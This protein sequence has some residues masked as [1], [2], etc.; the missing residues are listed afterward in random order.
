MRNWRRMQ[1]GDRSSGGLG[2]V[3]VARAHPLMQAAFVRPARI[4]SPEKQPR[5][6]PSCCTS[7]RT[8]LNCRV[9]HVLVTDGEQRA[10]LAAVRALAS[11]GHRVTVASSDGRSLAGASR[12]ASADIAVP[13]PGSSVATTIAALAEQLRVDVV[14]PITD[15]T[16]LQLLPRRD[17]VGAVIP[18][19]S[20]DAVR[21]IGDKHRVMEAADAVGIA[22]PRQ[23]LLR[24]ADDPLP[25]D[26]RLPLVVKPHRTVVQLAEGPV[27]LRVAYAADVRA[28]TST[29]AALPAE[30]FPVLLQERVVGPGVGVFLLRWNGRTL[31]QFSHRRLR[32]KPPSGG[33][34]VYRESIAMDPELLART[35]RLLDRFEWQGVA[36]VEYKVDGRSGTPYIMEINGRLWGSLQ[37]AIDAGVNFPVQL[38]E[39][40]TTEPPVARSAAAYRVGVRSRWFWGDVDQLISR[41]RRTRRALALPPDAPGRL[42]ALLEFLAASLRPWEEEVFRWSDPRPFLRE[43][44]LWLTGRE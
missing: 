26:L 9:V 6:S 11:A 2:V 24:R 27:Q 39:A 37:L 29:L 34:S 16:L 4:Y 41:L 43:S 1:I 3:T 5:S 17:S 8:G 28:L 12:Y 7:A 18:F 42:R 21:A 30:A 23:W 33:V 14:L 20:V 13:T 36:M 35:E 25:G 40:A 19:P 32:E 31:A 38:V 15:A 22:V 10:A 44:R